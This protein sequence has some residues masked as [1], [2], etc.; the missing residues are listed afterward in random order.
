M[1]AAGGAEG[2]RPGTADPG[3]DV[4]PGP[5]A[6][7]GGDPG[8]GRG[9]VAEAGVEAVEGDEEVVTP[10]GRDKRCRVGCDD[11]GEAFDFVEAG[12]GVVREEGSVRAAPTSF[13]GGHPGD[14]AGGGGFARNGADEGVGPGP[15]EQG[16]RQPFGLGPL[17]HREGGG[18]TRKIEAKGSHLGPPGCWYRI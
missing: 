16:D 1:G 5:G 18:E 11:T 17:P 14:K 9:F 6:D 13:A 10:A 4:A 3:T 12:G 2:Q 8:R 7:P 15:G